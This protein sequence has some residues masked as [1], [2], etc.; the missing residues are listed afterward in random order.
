[1]AKNSIH[2][3]E[4]TIV[5]PTITDTRLRALMTKIKYFVPWTGL[6]YDISQYKDPRTSSFTWALA[7]LKKQT[8][9]GILEPIGFSDTYHTFWY[10]M[11]VKPD[12]AEVFAALPTRYEDEVS[13]FSFI[14]PKD[15][16]DLNN[17][18]EYRSAWYDRGVVT[19]YW[20]GE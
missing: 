9:N 11:L 5:V 7:E 18:Q 3:P 12:L 13:H 16:V 17:N 19:W 10:S 1:M 4:K 2:I 14:W 6:E 15:A 20:K 8:I